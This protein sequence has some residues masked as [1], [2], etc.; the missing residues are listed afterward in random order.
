MLE[1]YGL[2]GNIRVPFLY[3]G[4]DNSLAGFFQSNTRALIVGQMNPVSGSA[5]PDVA[6]QV[7]GNEDYLFGVGSMVSEMIKVYRKN[8]AVAE[9]WALPLLDD[10]AAI[11]SEWTVTISNTPITRSDIVYLM[12]AGQQYR[13]IATS[14]DTEATIAQRLSDEI[15]DDPTAVVVATAAAG[16]ITL[17][18]K[19][20]GEAA[21]QLDVRS[22]YRRQRMPKPI[23]LGVTIAQTV[24]GAGNPD[25]SVAVGNLSDEPFDWVAFPYLDG[26]NL[27]SIDD[28]YS[29]YTGRWN[30]MQ[31]LYG[32]VLSAYQA[33][34]AQRVALGDTLNNQHLSILGLYGSPT[35]SYLISAALTGKCQLHLSDAP[36]LSRPLQTIP[37]ACVLAPEIEDVD[38]KQVRQVMYFSGIGGVHVRRDGTVCID[39]VLTTYHT[40]RWG[41]DDPS[42]LDI[43][44]L[45]QLQYLIRYLNQRITSIFP[46]HALKGDGEYLPPGSYTATPQIIKSYLV[47]FA[48]ELNWLNVLE[49]VDRFKNLLE[50]ERDPIDPNVVNMIIRPDFVNQF[51]IGKILTQ[52]FLEYPQQAIPGLEG[53]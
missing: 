6:Q 45:A 19:H 26:A 21:G 38:D 9:I 51:R 4:V 34:P 1:E 36:E 10:A 7:F 14:Q 50:V 20:G 23:E 31:Q 16:V 30:A 12:I 48:Q 13:A 18:A 15:N 27:V 43:Q 53:N 42:Y 3:F 8:N 25:C 39:R 49:D 37:L 28:E 46:R 29:D 17:V 11:K 32:H 35:P 44:T 41:A 5:T 47:S 22:E 24:V 40:N 2:P 33:S 52:F